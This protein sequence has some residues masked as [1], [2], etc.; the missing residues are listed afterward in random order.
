MENTLVGAV[1]Y[2]V[3]I[4]KSL[5]SVKCPWLMKGNILQKMKRVERKE[6]EEE[7]ILHSTVS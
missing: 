2:W 3:L 7:N 4:T 5:K 1:I 6:V